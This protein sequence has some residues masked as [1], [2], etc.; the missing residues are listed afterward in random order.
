MATPLVTEYTVLAMANNI[1]DRKTTKLLWERNRRWTNPN[2]HNRIHHYKP[3][4]AYAIHGLKVKAVKRRKDLY[5]RFITR[6][7]IA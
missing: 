1:Y 6:K 3:Y 5:T 2:L 4:L 7:Q